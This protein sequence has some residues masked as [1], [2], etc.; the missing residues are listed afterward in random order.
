MKAYQL[1]LAGALLLGPATVSMAQ[2]DTKAVVEQTKQLIQTKG[3][4]FDK[5]VK[6]LYKTN[7][8]NPPR[9][10]PSDARSITTKILPMLLSLLIMLWL[11]TTRML[12]PTS[13]RVILLSPMTTE[14]QLPRS[15]SRLSTSLRRTLTLII[16]MP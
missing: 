7:K 11:R 13:S 4:D 3:A 14:V 2:T 12:M 6:E 15:I 10:W 8:K 16:N 5:Q 1:L 9:W